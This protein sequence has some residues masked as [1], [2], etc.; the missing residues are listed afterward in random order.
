MDNA[1]AQNTALLNQKQTKQ[2]M[3]LAAAEEA[4]R[5][6]RF[7]WDAAEHQRVEDYWGGRGGLPGLQTPQGPALGPMPLR[8]IP[9]P[10]APGPGLMTPDTPAPAPAP[11]PGATGSVVDQ[12]LPEWARM[13]QQAGL[14]NNYL[15]TVSMLESSGGAN[16]GDGKYVGVF[17]IGPEVAEP[18]RRNARAASRPPASTRRWQPSW[19]ARTRLSCA[20]A[21]AREPEGWEIYLAHQ[22][23]AS[24]ASALLA[25]PQQRAVDV[26][27]AVYG[28]SLKAQQA[29]IKNGGNTNMSAGEFTAL[30]KSKFAG[31]RPTPFTGEATADPYAQHPTLGSPAQARFDLGLSGFP[32]ETRPHPERSGAAP[33]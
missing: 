26:L 1:I 22:Q 17:Q 15:E 18:V 20:S 28:D 12:L 9:A 21:S 13:E 4:R 8:N 10:V 31:G 2:Q 5:A 32:Q 3:G 23:G 27:T 29:I 6:Q 14:P 19:L 24:G 30:W 25:A 33:W 7:G 16:T 11:T